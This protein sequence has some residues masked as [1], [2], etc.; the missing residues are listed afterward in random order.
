M[1]IMITTEKILEEIRS[2]PLIPIS[3]ENFDDKFFLQVEST[4]V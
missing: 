2:V 1:K 4:C 3:D